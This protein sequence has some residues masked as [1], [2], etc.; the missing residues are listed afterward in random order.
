MI[1]LIEKL[2]S[3]SLARKFWVLFFIATWDAWIMPLISALLYATNLYELDFFQANYAEFLWNNTQSFFSAKLI[4]EP[5]YYYIYIYIFSGE[6]DTLYVSDWGKPVVFLNV[7]HIISLALFIALLLRSNLPKNK[8]YIFSSLGVIAYYG[9][10]F[11]T[12]FIYLFSIFIL[13]SVFPNISA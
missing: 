10:G 3:Y 2:E 11:L 8:K 9:L 6:L 5:S 13:G 1:K 7:F 4:T 12:V